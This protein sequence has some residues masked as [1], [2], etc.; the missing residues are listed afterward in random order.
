MKLN[1]A[2]AKIKTHYQ[3]LLTEVKQAFENA[4]D[5][6]INVD[7]FIKI[8]LPL[9]IPDQI[10]MQIV[11]EYKID[12][13]ETENNISVNPS[14]KS[15]HIKFP[16]A[17]LEQ[18][19]KEIVVNSGVSSIGNFELVKPKSTRGRKPGSKNKPKE[20]EVEE[21]N[22]PEPIAA[23]AVEQKTVVQ[24]TH[25]KTKEQPKVFRVAPKEKTRSATMSAH[26]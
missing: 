7:S 4:I 1:E 6:Q 25:Y 22:I 9:N 17:F 26:K 13:W 23:K 24:P 5:N 16:V 19:E 14:E 12:G 2:Y 3:N 21:N 20:I 10:I 15:I 11:A 8:S 18:T